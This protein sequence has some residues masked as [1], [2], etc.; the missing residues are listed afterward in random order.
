[1][2]NQFVYNKTLIL[3]DPTYSDVSIV[4]GDETYLCHQSVLF[5]EGLPMYT[6]QCDPNIYV[7]L[8]KFIYAGKLSNP[9]KCCTTLYSAL[10]SDFLKHLSLR[11]KLNRYLWDTLNNPTIDNAVD[12]LE[13]CT[14]RIE[15]PWQ[16]YFHALHLVKGNV[17]DFISDNHDEVLKSIAFLNIKKATLK[18]IL[19]LDRVCEKFTS[20]IK[21]FKAVINF[22]D[23]QI[24]KLYPI[25]YR[26]FLGDDLIKLIRFPTMTE[27]EFLVCIERDPTI[28]WDMARTNILAEIRGGPPNEYGFSNVKR[29]EE[30]I[31]IDYERQRFLVHVNCETSRRIIGEIPTS[32]TVFSVSSPVALIDV[33]LRRLECKPV[34][35]RVTLKNV[36]GKILAS[37]NATAKSFRNSISYQPVPL[38]P[39]VELRPQR[40]YMLEIEYIGCGQV[41]FDLRDAAA[42]MSCKINTRAG[43]G[44]DGDFCIQIEKINNMLMAMSIVKV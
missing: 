36:K 20:E 42:S 12:I 39:S 40:K 4:V 1:M 28:L 29:R 16:N 2:N 35:M 25:G 26:Q 23:H 34:N 7:I 33:W 6:G 11:T 24:D 10:Q 3:N 30:T 22:A 14:E 38:T 5:A 43:D 19:E 8:L 21:I 9:M 32:P 18:E 41:E 17:L 27:S 15:H 13:H 44:S 37:G 31:L